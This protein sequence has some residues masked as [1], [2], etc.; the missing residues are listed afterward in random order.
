MYLACMYIP[1]GLPGL[2]ARIDEAGNVLIEM[3]TGTVSVV[4]ELM[5]ADSL[6]AIPAVVRESLLIEL[7]DKANAYIIAEKMVPGVPKK[8][9]KKDMKKP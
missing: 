8:E 9:K 1:A 2:R 4:E 6:A 7:T 3:E 5:E